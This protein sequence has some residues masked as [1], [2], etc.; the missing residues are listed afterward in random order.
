MSRR[1]NFK[2]VQKMT[3][4]FLTQLY[5]HVLKGIKTI[6]QEKI[7][8]DLQLA[9]ERKQVKLPNCIK[10][11]RVNILVLF[12]ISEEMLSAFHHRV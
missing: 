10:R 11:A 1:V 4:K 8:L 5:Q 12:L 2:L 9:P 7:S 6:Q 3:S